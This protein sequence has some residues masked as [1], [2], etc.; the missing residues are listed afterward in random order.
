[1]V[2]WDERVE[3]L[4]SFLRELYSRDPF[5]KVAVPKGVRWGRVEEYNFLAANSVNMIKLTWYSKT[6]GHDTRSGK[7]EIQDMLIRLPREQGISK[8]GHLKLIATIELI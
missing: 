7:F 2:P 8:R 6:V 5:E 1:M 4:A 3:A